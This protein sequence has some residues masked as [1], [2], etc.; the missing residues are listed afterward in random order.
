MVAEAAREAA[1]SPPR[2]DA[3]DD[4]EAPAAAGR[5]T[6]AKVEFDEPIEPSPPKRRMGRYGLT[7]PLT[8]RV[9]AVNL[10]AL[11]I[12]VAGIL[13][14]DEY[15]SNLIDAELHGLRAQGEMIVGALGEGAVEEFEGG[16]QRLVQEKARQMVRRLV[17][18]TRRRERLFDQT[19]ELVAD[20]R[21]LFGSGGAI[22]VELLPS[23]VEHGLVRRLVFGLY[24][25]VVNWL[26]TRDRLEP[27]VESPEQRANNYPEVIKALL[28]ETGYAMRSGP[29]GGIVLTVAL[30]VQRYKQV[31]GALLV[32]V[33]SENIEESLR[34]VRLDIIKVL[35]ISLGVTVMLSVYLAGTI[36][37]PIRRLAAAAEQV[38][39]GHGRERLIPDFATRDDEIGELALALRE[40]TEA[41]W[42]RLDAIERFAADVAHELKNPLSSL[43]SAVETVSRIEDSAK[44]G[45]LLGIILEDV[46]RLDRLISEISS[47]SRLDS[48]LSRERSAPVDLGH[49]LAS[50]AATY[51]ET[52]R[53]D[54]PQV[55]VES[56]E[57]TRL[58]VSGLAN[59]LGQVFRNL[60]DNAIS[61][62]PPN[63]RIRITAARETGWIRIAVDD[64]GP[65]IPEDKLEAIFERF[66]S[67]RPA[68]EKFGTHSGLGLSISRQIVEAHGGRL[69]A[70][71]RR[72][73]SGA[74]RGARFIV[75]L[76]Q[77]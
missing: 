43:R 56:P 35:G 13:Y 53:A 65:G 69:W 5:T 41:L 60:I 58:V 20:S 62:S 52:A 73:E 27:Y 57:G 19:G 15:E 8:R 24:D 55:A 6:E 70:E 51:R 71:N 26:P 3:R 45:R 37:R 31:V 11:G 42:R 76:P 36:T 14:L 63:A 75:R 47:A 9:L 74:I 21:V 16:Q 18:P 61:F 38:R 28:G 64:D 77:L 30:P 59:R 32:S 34:A 46:E 72:D 25:R 49:L 10:M 67:E 4:T 1:D 66:Y 7:S 40:M 33:G 44:R 39:R 17:G 22:A 54:S 23:P 50:V 68:G 12:L 48:E 2:D 29:A